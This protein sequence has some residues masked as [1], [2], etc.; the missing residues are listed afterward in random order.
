MRRAKQ[1]EIMP[2]C[3]TRRIAA[4]LGVASLSMA[5]AAV[6]LGVGMMRVFLLAETR[7]PGWAERTR[8]RKCHFGKVVEMLGKFSSDLSV[9]HETFRAVQVGS[10]DFHTISAMQHPDVRARERLLREVLA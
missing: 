7:L 8:T 3:S 10:N 5:I 4:A 9:R 1:E 6:V 2:I